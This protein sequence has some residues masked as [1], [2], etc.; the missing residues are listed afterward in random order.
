MRLLAYGLKWAA[1]QRVF[2]NLDVSK[3][4]ATVPE[5]KDRILQEIDSSLGLLSMT[6]QLKD[7]LVNSAIADCPTGDRYNRDKQAGQLFFK[8]AG[9]S[10]MYGRFAEAERHYRLAHECY[11]AALGPDHADTM[12]P[13]T[14]LAIVLK[15]QGRFDEAETLFRQSLNVRSTFSND[16]DTLTTLSLLGELFV[17]Q[18]RMEE[19]E[20]MY[21]QS[22][23]GRLKKLGE[24][25]P[26]TLM[27][28]CSLACLQRDMGRLEEARG[29]FKQALEGQIELGEMPRT[30]IAM[31]EYAELLRIEDR[32]GEAYDLLHKAWEGLEKV[33]GG[34]HPDS[35]LA[36]HRLASVLIDQGKAEEALPLCI[37][38][39]EGRVR[40]LGAEHRHA[41]ESE[42]LLDKARL[43][44]QASAKEES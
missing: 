27:T 3:A 21:R 40:V 31:C 2:I 35:L 34:N 7:A 23:D 14:S 41:V 33:N 11:E 26:Y 15:D 16:F 44:A 20:P 13:L 19:A 32:L 12:K 9:I 29:L 30:F 22:L 4:E 10:T 25:H 6:H 24:K 38:A 8:A 5:D 18:G 36:L 1:L 42:K 43:R 37:K 17:L 28:L 39:K